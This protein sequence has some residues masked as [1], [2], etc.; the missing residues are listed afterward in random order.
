[1]ERIL[2]SFLQKC[3]I[4]LLTVVIFCLKLIQVHATTKNDEMFPLPEN[5]KSNVEFWIKVYTLYNSDEI[6]IHDSENLEIIYE[7]V[8]VKQLF[9]DKKISTKT[10]WQEVEKIKKEYSDILYRLSTYKEI[11]P[12]F[13]DMK[14]RFVYNLFNST[15]SPTVFKHAAQR[16]RG[17]QGLR[18]E[19][20]K[21]L[22][23]SGRY[24]DHIITIFRKYEIPV[25]LIALPHVESSFNHK[26]YSKFGAAGIWQFTRGTGRRFLKINYTVDER[27]DPIKSTEAAA[28]LLKQ[29]YEALGTWPLAITSYNHGLSGIKRAISGLKTNDIGVIVEKYESRNFKFASR[30]FYA[31]FLAA[32]EVRNNYKIYF[33][34]ILFE[35]PDKYLTFVVPDYV[36]IS[37]LTNKLEITIDH[38]KQLNPS[39]RNN[40]LTSKRHLPKGFELRIPWRPDFDPNVFYA[41]MP[42]AEKFQNQ[43]STDWYQVEKG[44][45]L[46]KI[47]KQFNT[48]VVDL[49]ELNDIR[50][51]HQIYIGQ[52]LRL[53][54]EETLLAEETS[55]ITSV[56]N[57]TIKSMEKDKLKFVKEET[58]SK[59]RSGDQASASSAS[60]KI[61]EPL[62]G[63]IK[64]E[65]PEE[66]LTNEAQTKSATPASPVV[67]KRITRKMKPS[68][69]SI[70]V[71]P[72]ET[73][74]HYA[75]WLGVATQELR[76]LNGFRFGQ[77]IHLGQKIKLM[78]REISEREFHRKRREYHRGIEE[79][80]FASFA[81]EG[82]VVHK[83]RRGENIWYL[84]NYV[85]EIPY[86]LVLKYNPN[87]SL[88]RLTNGDELIIPIVEPTN[89]NR[90]IG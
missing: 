4:C 70:Y 54:P 71:Q 3:I 81:V 19:F 2:K 84:C 43:V 5:L 56:E 38:I 52:V 24:A 76:D 34:E 57:A 20:K 68:Y 51:P 78:F 79:D 6:I 75:D 32:L 42:T 74:G 60:S 50:N 11:D 45:N 88:E 41:Q 21:G 44:D 40:V 9:G 65:S 63:R 61:S 18:D 13:L 82:V 59:I 30:N 29:N 62:T 39:L 67:E 77:D 35:R 8:D 58:D 10:I 86:W 7:I 22:I 23:R 17:Q 16:I 66:K 1:M 69:G 55:N 26:A 48:T 80:F 37:T 14:E 25:E 73:L 46:Q 47:A 49:M 72:E 15:P 31:E 85:Y 27:F 64:E 83:I 36:K 28:K 89:N 90:K 87:L 12:D 33:G 53:K